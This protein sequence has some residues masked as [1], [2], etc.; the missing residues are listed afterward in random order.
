MAA[1]GAPAG[2]TATRGIVMAAPEQLV[3]VTAT[4]GVAMAAKPR[5]QEQQRHM[6]S[7]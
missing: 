3:G 7:L 6:G 5:Q 1:N 2:A 4:R